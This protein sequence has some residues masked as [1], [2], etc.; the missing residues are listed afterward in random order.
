MINRVKRNAI[1]Y[2]YMIDLNTIV[3]FSFRIN[4]DALL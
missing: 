2:V 4:S 3:R 1:Y